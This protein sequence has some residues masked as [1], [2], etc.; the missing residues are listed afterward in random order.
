MGHTVLDVCLKR[1]EVFELFTNVW[2]CDDFNTTKANKEIYNM[3]AKALDRKVED[4]IFLDD[5]YNADK[6][7]VEAGMIVCG[8]FDESSEEYTADIKNIANYYIN[9]FSELLEIIS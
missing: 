7:A 4:V 8:V 3:A 6:T 1:L 5:N 2:S 9:D